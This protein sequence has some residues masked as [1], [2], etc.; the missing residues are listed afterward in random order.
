MNS[1]QRVTT[2][3]HPGILG[4][5]CIGLVLSC[6]GCAMTVGSRVTAVGARIGCP[7][8]Q[9]ADDVFGVAGMSLLS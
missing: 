9:R 7:L 3:V 5:A 2:T 8:G 4:G 6:A 1:T